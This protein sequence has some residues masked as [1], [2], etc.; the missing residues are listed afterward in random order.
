MVQAIATIKVVGTTPETKPRKGAEML[1]FLAVTFFALVA[2]A[3]SVGYAADAPKAVNRPYTINPGD[4]IEIYVWGEE[5]LQRQV[6]ILPDGS[7]AFPLV[8]RIAAAGKLPSAIE[9]EISQGLKTQYRGEVPQVTVSVKAPS[10][11]T[12]S[13]VGRVKNPGNM[14]P[15]RYLN[16]MEAIALSGGPDEFANLDN[17]TI[18]RK[19]GTG[20]T[21]MKVRLSAAFKGSPNITAEML[22][23]IET[24]DTVIVP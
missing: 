14:T 23:Q 6:R 4:E 22:P 13:I 1:R 12:F 19:V 7:F 11:M 24:G 15:G 9:A 20:I 21:L 10:G 8:G 17:V 18:I 3:A 16:V 5:R 2:S